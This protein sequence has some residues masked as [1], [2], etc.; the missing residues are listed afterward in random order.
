MAIHSQPIDQMSSRFGEVVLFLVVI[1]I[2]IHIEYDNDT[3]TIWLL[4]FVV[5]HSIQTFDFFA[6]NY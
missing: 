5:Y 6:D 3:L 1:L 4:R 2:D